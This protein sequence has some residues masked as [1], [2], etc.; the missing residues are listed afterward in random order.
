METHRLNAMMRLSGRIAV[1][2]VR[3]LPVV[4]LPLLVACSDQRA[5]F[6]I[7]GSAHSLSLIRVTGMPWAS[8]AKYAVVAS[9]M[10]DCQRRHAMPEAGL[11]T[12]VE[13]F[14]PG[15]DAWI[16]RQNGRMFVVET[17]TCEGFARLD[18]VPDTGLGELM[19][20]FQLQGDA[21]VFLPA[22]KAADASAKAN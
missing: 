16:L 20:V 14:S 5:T 6:E 12:K 21:L 22:K 4:F 18:N 11:T 7:R 17:R 10:P 15:N 2:F 8:Q 3:Y 19:G 9:R 13:V 1:R